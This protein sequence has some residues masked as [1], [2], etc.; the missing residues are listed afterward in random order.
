[1]PV[2]L[3]IRETIWIENAPLSAQR[4]IAKSLT[5]ANPLWYRLQRMGK[6]KALYGVPK[7]FRYWERVSDTLRVGRGNL[8]RLEQYFITNNI[9]YE[10]ED[11][12]NHGERISLS[13]NVTFRAYQEGDLDTIVAHT[14]GI[15]RLDTGYGKTVL[16]CALTQRL[17]VVTLIL[18]PRLHLLE[19]FSEEYKK[20]FKYKVGIIQ[21]DRG[22][23]R[24]VTVASIATLQKRKD[25]QAKLTKEVGC[26]IVDE[27]HTAV[28]DRRLSLIQRFRP[29]YLYGL[30]ATPR[31]TDEQSEAI[32]FTFGPAIIDKDLEQM[33]PRVIQCI[34]QS[35]INVQEYADMVEEQ[36]SNDS[37]N[38]LIATCATDEVRQGRKVLI[39]TK[40]IVHYEM[41]ARD[42]RREF[43]VFSIASKDT[44]GDR[45]ALL[46]GLRDGSKDFD[47]ILGTYSMLSTG[48]DIP[49][50][51]TLIFAG[52]LRSDVLQEQSAGRILRLF[53]GKQTPKIIDIMDRYNPIFWNQARARMRWYKQQGWL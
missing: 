3:R 29:R 17:G 12:T 45:S 4:A 8:E 23:I 24:R 41:L 52:D 40:R 36:I 43:R 39:L 37:R 7:E 26:L 53:A 19:Q 51:D 11:E 47:V 20:W 32:F 18:V 13:G 6:T 46:K 34:C 42:L 21:G 27:A 30:T 15:I 9:P 44:A 28:T 2:T 50:L 49:K 35:P 48:V 14:H 22:D 5:L 38:V 16:A 1:M 10:I 33:S 25:L 31:R